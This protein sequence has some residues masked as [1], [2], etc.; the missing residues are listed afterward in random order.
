MV[1]AAAKTC[2]VHDM[3]ARLPDGYDTV[4]G[5]NGVGLSVGQ[6]QRICLARAVYGMP[7]VILL[8]EP[9][10]HLDAEGEIIL[11]R[12]LQALKSVGRT[13]IFAS[14]RNQVLSVAER[15]MI[16]RD[17]RLELDGPRAE[18]LDRLSRP[19]TGPTP[20]PTSAPSAPAPLAMSA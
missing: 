6:A 8:D 2:G 17:G 1:I 15:I 19:A 9:D 4:I 3:I 20:V 18:V 12:A 7:Q 16:V 13:I 14:H 5:W 10:A 11:S